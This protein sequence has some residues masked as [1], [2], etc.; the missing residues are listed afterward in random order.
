LSQTN[1]ARRFLLPF[2]VPGH[3]ISAPLFFFIPISVARIRRRFVCGNCWTIVPLFRLGKVI[4]FFASLL[5]AFPNCSIQRQAWILFQINDMK[6]FA[7]GVLHLFRSLEAE[8]R[9]Q[10]ISLDCDEKSCDDD[11]SP[12][13]PATPF[14]NP[15]RIINI[16]RTSTV[17]SDAFRCSI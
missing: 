8:A 13:S 9:I 11:E 10:R 16:S 14:R 17:S 2:I 1:A 4:L 15:Q 5:P 7:V 12:K 3:L 6:R